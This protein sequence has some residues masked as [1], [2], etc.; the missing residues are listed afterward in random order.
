MR[1]TRDYL[2]TQIPFEHIQIDEQVHRGSSAYYLQCIG[3]REG[4][5]KLY[6]DAGLLHLEGAASV[7]LC[8]SHSTL[9]SIRTRQRPRYNETDAEAWRR[10]REAA[11]RF[12]ERA[13]LL[14]PNLD[15]PLLPPES[16][17]LRNDE[18]EMPTIELNPSAPESVYSGEESQTDTKSPMMR[19]RRKK[20]EVVWLHDQEAKVADMD[21]AWYL[22][23]PGLVGAGTALIVVGVIGALSLSTWRRN[24]AS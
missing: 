20:E 18:L 13:K 15:V 9:S 19:R 6:L 3:G 2:P 17:D 16:D 22:Y 7:M 14:Q 23:I 21:N 11:S 5:A 4:L 12:F 10:D 8:S 24:Q 1:L